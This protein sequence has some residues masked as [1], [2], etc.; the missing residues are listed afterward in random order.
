MRLHHT[1]NML[2]AVAVV[3]NGLLLCVTY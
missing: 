3:Q 2:N 1:V